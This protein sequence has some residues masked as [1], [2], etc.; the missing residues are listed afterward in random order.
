[1]LEIART[2]SVTARGA[3]TTF[4]RTVVEEKASQMLNTLPRR[5]V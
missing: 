1:M 5:K 4:Q 2:D 3:I